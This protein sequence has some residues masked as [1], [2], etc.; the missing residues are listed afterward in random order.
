MQIPFLDLSRLHEPILND[1]HAVLDEVVRTSNLVGAKASRTFEEAFAAAHNRK[2]AAGCAS[3][4]D[5]LLLALLGLGIGRDHEVIVPAMTFVATAEAVVRAGATPVL[6]DVDPNSLLL[7][8]ATVAAV[9]TDRTRAVIP[10]H[11]YGHVVPFDLLEAWVSDG[12]YVIE[13]AAQAHLATWQGRPIGE[14]GHAA[15]FSFYPGKNL[16]AL[17]DAGLVVS[18]D[19]DLLARVRRIRDHGSDTRYLHQEIGLCSRLDGIQAGV[20]AVKLPHLTGWNE[21]RATLAERYRSHLTGAEEAGLSL[22]PWEPGANHHLFVVRVSGGKRDAVKDRMEAA[23]IGTGIHY[24][25]PLSRQPALASW[26]R[27]CPSAEHA[28]T[29]ILSLP[30]DPLMTVEEADTVADELLRLI[31]S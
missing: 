24:P 13:D 2:G 26:Q 31:G 6:A 5:A 10:V 11:L 29:E 22:V 17:G 14:V 27:N 23:G 25:V 19:E 21:Q 20:L 8:K 4:T 9:R 18:D 12:L 15:C 7:T 1:L 28:A 16:G 30:M 3:G